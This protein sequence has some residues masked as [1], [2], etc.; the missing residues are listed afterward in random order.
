MSGKKESGH[1][2][3]DE[4]IRS[5]LRT[6]SRY[7]T[8]SYIYVLSEEKKSY[9]CITGRINLTS[10]SR[11]GLKASD[12]YGGGGGHILNYFSDFTSLMIL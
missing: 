6:K 10:V 12:S 1:R 2:L 8:I 9:I 11:N 7:K 4:E 5:R 3:Q